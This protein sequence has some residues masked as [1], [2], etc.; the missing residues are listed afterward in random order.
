LRPF[1]DKSPS[2]ALVVIVVIVVLL[3]SLLGIVGVYIFGKLSH[4]F[5]QLIVVEILPF[6]LIVLILVLVLVLI[7]VHFL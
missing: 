5:S 7:F 6:L 4:V 1:P 2:Y 3:P